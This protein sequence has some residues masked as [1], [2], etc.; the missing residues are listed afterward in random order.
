M[1]PREPRGRTLAIVLLL[2]LLLWWIA[3]AR[4]VEHAEALPLAHDA[5]Y[6]ARHA[7]GV[8]WGRGPSED[9][10]ACHFAGGSLGMGLRK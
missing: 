9:L 5:Q 8:R 7:R 3:C 10:R 2:P 1:T 6:V 4:V